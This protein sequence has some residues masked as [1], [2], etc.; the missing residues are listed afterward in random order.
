MTGQINVSADAGTASA[1]SD[2][3]NATAYAQVDA[4]A[5]G[6]NGDVVGDGTG[7]ISAAATGGLATSAAYNS[8]ANAHAIAAAEA[9]ARGIN[10]NVTGDIGTIVATATGGTATA[11]GVYAYARSHAT[12]N[13]IHGEQTVGDIIGSIDAAATGGTATA[14]STGSIGSSYASADA[15]AYAYGISDEVFIGDVTGSIRATATGGTAVSSREATAVARAYGIE[16]DMTGDITGTIDAT[17]T[18]GTATA[19]VNANADAYAAAYGMY[20]DLNGDLNGAVTATG[21]GGTATA[22]DGNAS[23]GTSALGI[24]GDVTGNVGGTIDATAFGGSASSPVFGPG[25]SDAFAITYTFVCGLREDVTGDINGTINSTAFGG[26]TTGNFVDARVYSYGIWGDFMGDVTGTINA[27]AA[28]GTSTGGSSV[29][30]KADAYGIYGDTVQINNFSGT[31]SATAVAGLETLSAP[32][33]PIASINTIEP[34][35]IVPMGT[36][37]RAN[38]YGIYAE[39]TLYLNAPTGSIHAAIEVPAGYTLMDLPEGSAAY[40]ICGGTGDDMVRLGNMDI[41]GDIDLRTGNNDLYIFGKTRVKGNVTATGG[42]N[43]YSFELYENPADLRNSKLMVDGRVSEPNGAS[44]AAYAAPGQTARN[45]VGKKY[46]VITATDGVEG[47]FVENAK[48][49]FDL[50][51]EQSD[52]NVVITATGVKGQTGSSTP[53]A[54]SVSKATVHAARTVMYDLSAHS[55]AMRTFLRGID[56]ADAAPEGPAGP[57]VDKLKN[58]EWMLFARQ[59]NDFG[60]QDSDGGIAGYDWQTSGFMLGTERLLT[61]NLVAGLSGGGTWT[62]LDGK[63]GAGGGSSDMFVTSLN[64]NWFTETWF[65]ESGLCY[66]HAD[67]DAQRI[68][69]DDQYYTGDYNSDLY[70]G[71][72]EFGY[73][74]TGKKYSMEPYFRT[75]YIHG[76]HDGYEDEGGSNPLTVDSHETDNCQIE[77]GLRARRDWAMKNGDRLGIEM[78][79]AWR[80]ELMDDSVSANG[81][82]LGV[83]QSLRSPSADRDALALGIKTDW[84]MSDAI[85]V[86]VEYAPTIAGNWHNHALNGMV[87]YEF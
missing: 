26:T 46:E 12:A 54:N 14:T 25:A 22:T 80:H 53:S 65:A 32:A 49:M 28:G 87:K 11:T 17:A 61:P 47:T 5:Y 15:S 21:I 68:A 72:L 3:A 18:G 29:D 16:G 34:L 81:S 41:V 79:A 55:S 75:S 19:D 6:I 7:I 8:T 13:G 66:A 84:V 2:G 23:A 67:N 35:I 24:R 74:K 62:D 50:K 52:T 69:T 39:D 70:G 33:D 63:E 20:G 48:S 9:L 73:T 43:N 60:S 1:A 42:Y 36:L 31:I 85:T 76:R 83:D 58:G 57:E 77:T 51:V 78:K 40:A 64:L 59:V 44:I 10:G 71:W 45:I 56:S 27:R 82:L 37:S 30:A 86:G 38:A 4:T